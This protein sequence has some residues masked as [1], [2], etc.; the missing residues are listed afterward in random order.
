MH[1]TPQYTIR[2]HA[3]PTGS[4]CMKNAQTSEDPGLRTEGSVQQRRLPLR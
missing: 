2:E 3:G 4:R 1:V